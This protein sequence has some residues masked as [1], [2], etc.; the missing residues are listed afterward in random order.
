MS[1]VQTVRLATLPSGLRPNKF[2]QDDGD[3][4]G[5]RENAQTVIG[6]IILLYLTR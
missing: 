2:R 1:T 5:I 3:D 6:G 4:A